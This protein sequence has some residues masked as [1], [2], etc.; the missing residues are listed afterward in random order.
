MVITLG[1]PLAGIDD[2]KDMGFQTEL[3][4]QGYLEAVPKI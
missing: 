1:Q 3:S 4:G 2:G